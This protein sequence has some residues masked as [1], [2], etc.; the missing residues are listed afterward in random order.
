MPRALRKDMPE[1]IYLVH[2]DSTDT[3]LAR[4]PNFWVAERQNDST[5]A[6]EP[7]PPAV[8]ATE[9]SEPEAV[10]IDGDETNG[11]AET[12]GFLVCAIGN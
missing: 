7:V 9:L 11:G 6:P 1:P 5:R 4:G 10:D 3:T 8:C 12:N 2:C